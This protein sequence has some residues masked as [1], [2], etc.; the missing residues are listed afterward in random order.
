MNI[1][2]CI[3]GYGR[4]GKAIESIL[5]LHH[6][7]LHSIIQ[8]EEDWN[9]PGV[10]DCDVAIDFSLPHTAKNNI[11]QC[12]KAH[13]PVVSGTTGWLD[14]MDSIKNAIKAHP[15]AAFLYGSNFSLGMNLFFKI[16]TFTAKLMQSDPSYH[17]S[18]TEVHHT[19]K[20]DAPSGTAIR[21]A[22]DI[23][24][25]HPNLDS[26]VN[27]TSS[28]PQ[29][30]DI[31]S[32]RI[33]DVPGTHRIHYENEIDSIQIEH[34]AKSRQGFAQGAVLAAKWLVGKTGFYNIGD[35]VDDL[36]RKNL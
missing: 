18:M 1:R 30:L 27:E 36:L 25:I 23:I 6:C 20:L 11:L 24:D 3:I 17:I 4:M 22:N 9:K 31:I 28:S 32:E 34:I 26:W 7:S 35:Y 29:A 8:R 16:N 21:L 2:V 10:L 13:V 14:E 5:A 15:Q 12:I 33:P 19:K